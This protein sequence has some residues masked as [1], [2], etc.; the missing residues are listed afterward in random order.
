MEN[1]KCRKCGKTYPL[2]KNYFYERKLNKGK[3]PNNTYFLRKCIIC[4]KRERKYYN[5]REKTLNRKLYSNNL[6]FQMW[7]RA[8][9]R[10]INKNLEF[11]I[12]IEDIK[13]PKYCPILNIEIKQCFG[14][15]GD[16]SPSLDRI[17]VNKG[18]IKGNIQVIS[19]MA[20][21]MKAHA[22]FELLKTFSKNITTYIKNYQVQDKLDEFRETPEVDNPE[23]SSLNSIKVD[24]KVQRL[25]GEELT[26]NPSTS[27]QQIKK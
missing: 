11:N 27:V 20:N 6:E 26:N 1:R 8:K 25:E 13:I 4:Y 17:N 9:Y 16:S 15:A 22:T 23:P 5:F 24:E 2:T 7:K 10:A 18:Y 3:N 14:A 21:I 19:R 12:E